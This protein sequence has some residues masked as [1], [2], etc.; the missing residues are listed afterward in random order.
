[1]PEDNL[2]Q[3]AIERSLKAQTSDDSGVADSLSDLLDTLSDEEQIKMFSELSQREIRHL[4]VVSTMD[5]DLFN[6]FIGEYLEMKVSKRRKG[7]GELSEVADSFAGVFNQ[8]QG[9]IMD[10]IKGLVQ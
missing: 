7:R 9:G 4:S 8:E 10:R 1:M 3:K 6:K 5:D 2:D